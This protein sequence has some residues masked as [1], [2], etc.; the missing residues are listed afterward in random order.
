MNHA[1]EP[2]FFVALATNSSRDNGVKDAA[3]HAD[4]GVPAIE[5]ARVI[6]GC[7]EEK[8]AHASRRAS[9]LLSRPESD[10]GTAP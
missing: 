3:A 6:V 8:C 9:R 7:E 10:V 4:V 2:I 5:A 1:V